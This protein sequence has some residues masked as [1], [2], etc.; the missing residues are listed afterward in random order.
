AV[1]TL[2]LS[3]H[4]LSAQPPAAPAPV[5]AMLIP[6]SEDVR[7]HEIVSAASP[8]RIEQDIRA[9]VRFGTRHTLSDTL[10]NSRGIG[11][12]RRW[13]YDEFQKISASCGGCLEVRYVQGIEKGSPNSRIREDINI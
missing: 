2:P 5:P 7:V 1:V 12:A 11:A 9:L 8:E 3:T 13:I 6:S 10:S 4:T